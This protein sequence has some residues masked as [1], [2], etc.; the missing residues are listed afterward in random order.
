MSD[1]IDLTASNWAWATLLAQNAQAQTEWFNRLQNLP[2]DRAQLTAPRAENIDANEENRNQ[3]PSA[4]IDRQQREAI[5]FAR[6]GSIIGE[7][8]LA[9]TFRR[10][11]SEYAVA[12]INTPRRNTISAREKA[13]SIAKQAASQVTERVDMVAS[14]WMAERAAALVPV[15]S[16]VQN[17]I[18]YY[19]HILFDTDEK[20][21]QYRLRYARDPQHA[22]RLM[23]KFAIG[24]LHPRGAAQKELLTRRLFEEL[25]DEES[26]IWT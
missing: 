20:Q 11:S 3:Q 7:G 16:Y 9:E 2:D 6:D 5:Q 1:C 22:R 15:P 12:T 26:Y 23:E 13:M 17:P 14:R 18:N 19:R 4:T 21:E 8:P 24:Q 10:N 25:P